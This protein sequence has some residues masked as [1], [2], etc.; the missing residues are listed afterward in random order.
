MDKD[1]IPLSTAG[2]EAQ[3]AQVIKLVGEST[4]IPVDTLA[5]ENRDIWAE[6]RENLIKS[7][8]KN[9]KSLDRIE[10]NRRLLSWPSMIPSR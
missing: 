1:G 8:P 5:S 6:A 9:A 2:L 7:S 4:A 3:I 10:S